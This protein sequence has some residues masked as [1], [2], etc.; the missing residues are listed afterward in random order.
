MTNLSLTTEKTTKMKNL[1]FWLT[2]I[3]VLTLSSCTTVTDN[4]KLF[5]IK[6]GDKWGYVD[7]KGQ[8]IINSQFED[9]YNFSEG[10]AAVE[11]EGVWGYIDKKGNVV[12]DFKYE[13]ADDFGEGLAPVQ[14]LR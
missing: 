1:L 12:I 6:A 8:Y 11:K 4:I 2:A 13:T 7:D 5:P 3:V 10:L 14:F 9:A